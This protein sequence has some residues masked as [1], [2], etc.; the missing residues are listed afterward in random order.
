M[1]SFNPGLL[2]ILG[3]GVFG[4]MLGAWFFQRIRFPQVVGYIVIGLIIGEFGLRIVT[5]EDI[6]DLRMFNLIALGVIGFLVGG[7]LRVAAFKKYGRQFAGILLGEGLLTFALVGGLTFGIVQIVTSNI[8]ISLASSVVFGAIASATDPASTLDVIWENRATGPMT[9]A[10]VAVIAL[11][12]ALAMILYAVS[13]GA[14]QLLSSGSG[15]ITQSLLRVNFEI[16]GALVLGIVAALTL[17]LCLRRW[18]ETE[19]GAAVAVGMIL[20]VISIAVHIKVDV[21]LATM[22]LGFMLANLE[23][24]RSEDLFKL[25]RS[26]SIP[27][28]V[29]F[30]VLVGARISI[31]NMTGWM[32]CLVMAYVI[33][34]SAGKI[35][36]AY[37]GARATGGTGEMQRYLGMGLST[38]GGIAIGLS[39]MAA[40]HFAGIEVLEG[41][42]LGDMIIFVVTATTLI[43]QLVGPSMVKLA[44]QLSGEA[45]RDITEEDVMAEMKVADALTRSPLLVGEGE[46]VGRAV[47]YFTEHDLLLYPVVD[48]R[49]EICGILTFD[50][51]KNVLVDRHSWDWLLVAD[52]MYPMLD[53]ATPDES[54]KDVYDKMCRL[55]IDQMPVLESRER[56]VPVGMLDVRS[57]KQKIHAEMLKRKTAPQQH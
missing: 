12:D 47:D 19:R 23:S 20:L 32:W 37:I 29:L 41:M 38:Q 46:P 55:K 45:G 11:D 7:E 26:F 57:I 43:V 5:A 49:H 3:L 2:F 24:R 21:I 17:I 36:G 4:G 9:S 44:L 27:I 15:S 18:A 33:T 34:R 35:A 13:V 16:G 54:L 6:L 8:A 39:I 31:G 40:E 28:Y 10:I 42:P 52:I 50:A 51:L 22:M 48:Q 56:R 25:M 14:A 1:E 30:F 53:S